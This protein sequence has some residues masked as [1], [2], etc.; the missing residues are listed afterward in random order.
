MD[1]EIA[2]YL[3]TW[4]SDLSVEQAADRIAVAEKRLAS[5]EAIEFAIIRRSTEQLIGWISFLAES[6]KSRAATTGFWLGRPYQEQGFMREAATPAMLMAADFLRVSTL[7][8]YVYPW[9]SASIGLLRTL[10]FHAHG[11]ASLYS[12][13]RDRTEEAFLF[14]RQ[15]AQ[16]EVAA[17]HAIQLEQW[18]GSTY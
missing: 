17:A 1:E 9:N 2:S 14:C 11:G 13:V 15:L 7:E 10:G 5:R 16:E 12:P 18:Y 8:A 3:T 4:P 6:P